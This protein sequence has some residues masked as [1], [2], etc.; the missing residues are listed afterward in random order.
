MN[1]GLTRMAAGDYETARAYFERAAIIT[2]NYSTLE[3]N[4][5]IVYDAMGMGPIAE[6]HFTRALALSPDATSHYYYARWLA[7]SRRGPEA[8]AH[9]RESIVNSPGLLDARHLLMRLLAAQDRDV[10]LRR[11]AAETLA[12][13]PTDADASAYA[14][15]ASPLSA[16][17]QDAMAYGLAALAARRFPDAAEW[18]R[19]GVL[20]DPRSPDAWNNRGWAQY[21]MGFDD[22]ARD[23]FQRALSINPAHDRAINNL[24]L[25]TSR[26][27]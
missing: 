4:L 10:D 8:I 25:V 23:G 26:Q 14:R 5:G 7:S 12:L 20:M 6:S 18:F 1:Y 3:I 11:A 19:A 21:E 15:G 17:P 22:A 13:D 2:P 24:A 9:L 27:K 16:R